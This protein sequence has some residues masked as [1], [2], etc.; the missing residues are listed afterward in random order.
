MGTDGEVP[1]QHNLQH[2]RHREHERYLPA[3]LG[4]THFAPRRRQ[5]GSKAPRGD[6]TGVEQL[7][8]KCLDRTLDWH[9]GDSAATLVAGGVVVAIIFGNG[10]GHSARVSRGGNALARP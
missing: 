8:D 2:D 10:V 1:R 6:N 7:F 5:T 9:V 3:R 4:A